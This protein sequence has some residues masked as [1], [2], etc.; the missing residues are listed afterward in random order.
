MPKSV[1]SQ[2]TMTSSLL[3]LS[4]FSFTLSA[5]GK[6]I[7]RVLK[8]KQLCQLVFEFTRTGPGGLIVIV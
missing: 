2:G 6:N 3:T 8:E 7:T 5:A 1:T 4:Y